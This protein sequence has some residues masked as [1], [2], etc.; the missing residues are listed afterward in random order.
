MA[1]RF[2]ALLR[3]GGAVRRRVVL[4]GLMASLAVGLVVMIVP[5]G[6][7]R[8]VGVLLVLVPLAVVL[9]GLV[10][11]LLE[12]PSLA[13]R[14]DATQSRFGARLDDASARFDDASARFDDLDERIAT[15][16]RH[17]RRSSEETNARLDDVLSLAITAQQDQAGLNDRLRS[18][19]QSLDNASAEARERADRV[20]AE[21]ERIEARTDRL[22]ESMLL[23]LDE[24]KTTSE[25]RHRDTSR[26]IERERRSRHLATAARD[27]G[28]RWPERVLLQMT[29]N[30]TGSTRLFDILRSHSDVY[31]EPL[32]F[33]WT[34]LGLDGRRYPVGLSDPPGAA[35][36]IVSQGE[37]GVGIRSMRPPM[38]GMAD[39]P[40]GSIALEKAHPQFFDFD[41]A[42]FDASLDEISRAHSL[43]VDVVYQIRPPLDIMWSMA[44]YKRRDPT[45]HGDLTVDGVPELVRAEYEAL[46]SLA[47]L[48]PG[49]V[50]DYSRISKDDEVMLE[51]S[52]LVAPDSTTEERESWLE[53]SFASTERTA[54]QGTAFVGEHEERTPA[55]PDGV[56]VRHE[57]H[58]AA[59]S[60]IYER[61]VDSIER[62]ATGGIR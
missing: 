31:V 30:R 61:L 10:E 23:R 41:V 19:I 25:G 51:L 33:I 11:T 54:I 43:S 44:E 47:Q 50:V 59:C 21:I 34:A 24:A 46:A 6:G 3:D 56:W 60:A 28:G 53:T 2:S 45:W 49:L 7:W 36:S 1:V 16:V 22:K 32:D 57:E 27:S 14:H 9:K 13:K 8:I 37:I 42:A 38:P 48:R 12:L 20:V 58:L 39:E 17:S 55:G 18:D 62:E 52:R 26:R 4:V 35:I 5:I 40:S 15:F 29:I